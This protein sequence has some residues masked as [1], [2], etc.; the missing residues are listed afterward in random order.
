MER[1]ESEHAY[2]QLRQ[3]SAPPRPRNVEE[4]SFAFIIGTE[5]TY[6]ITG[7]RL[8]TNRI[9]EMKQR[10]VLREGRRKAQARVCQRD[11]EGGTGQFRTKPW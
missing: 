1:V 8:S 9:N 4:T 6:V 5:S 2:R 3:N 11:S 10:G 7:S